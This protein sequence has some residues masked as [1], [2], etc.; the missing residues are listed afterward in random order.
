MTNQL[1]ELFALPIGLTPIITVGE[2]SLYGSQGL[3]DKLIYSISKSKRGKIFK[4]SITKMINTGTIIPCFA[5][6]NILTYFRRKISY[7]TSGG[8]LRILRIIVAGKKPIHHPLDYVLAFYDFN[9]NKIVLMISN[10]INEVFSSTA[11]DDNIALTLTHE[12]M[13]MFAHQN[14]NKFLS[15]FKD[16]LNSYYLSYFKTIFKLKDDKTIEKHIEQ[17]YRFLFLKGEMATSV[18]SL[19]SLLNTLLKLEKFS[20]L[21]KDEFK[22]VCLDYIKITRLLLQNDMVKLISLARTKFKYI[23]VP[24]YDSYKVSFG[25]LPI[26]GCMQELIYPS[27]VICGMT[28]IRLDSKIKNSLKLLG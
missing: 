22:K 8:L 26:K 24:L 20:T 18:V 12:M 16:E 25:R 23:V 17:V 11:S 1:N 4:S 19:S 2:I 21:S 3:N 14:P 15:V 28:D 10:H 9:T 27:E 7:D 6:N 13:H 5:D